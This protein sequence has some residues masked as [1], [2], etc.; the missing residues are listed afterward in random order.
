MEYNGVGEQETQQAGK[1]FAVQ[2]LALN[3]SS[4]I[5]DLEYSETEIIK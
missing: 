2:N 1:T 4:P 3:I 5:I